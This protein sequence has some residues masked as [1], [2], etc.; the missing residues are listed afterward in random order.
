MF[1]Q[2]GFESELLSD[3]S[4]DAEV[5]EESGSKNLEFQNFIF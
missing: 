1:C 3:G 4:S 2:A 5:K